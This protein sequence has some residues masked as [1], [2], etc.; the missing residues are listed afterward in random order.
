MQDILTYL[1]DWK[2]V[3]AVAIVCAAVHAVWH[4]VR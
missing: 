1:M 4:F 2:W 3:A